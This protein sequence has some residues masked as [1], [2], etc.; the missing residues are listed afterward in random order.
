MKWF[1][2]ILRTL[3]FLTIILVLWN[4]KLI[5]YGIDQLK[6]Q[7][8]IVMRARPIKE[9]LKNPTTKGIYK[10]KLPLIAEIKKFAVDSLGLKQTDNYTTFYDQYDKP[11]LWVLTASEPFAL[12]AYQWYFPFLGNVSYKGF[13]IRQNGER[14]KKMLDKKGLDTDLSPTGG[15]STLGWFKDPV[16]SNFLKRPVGRIAETIIHELTHATVYLP[17]SVDYNENLATFVGEKG[18]ERFLIYKYGAGSKQLED[19]R[20]YKADEELYGNQFL[21]GTS[22]LD[23]LYRSFETTTLSVNEKLFLKYKTITQ[24]MLELNKQL[25]YTKKDYT[26]DFKKE[27]FPD[28][29]WFLSNSRYR[30]N[31]EEFEKEFREKNGSDLKTFVLS[32]IQKD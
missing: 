1:K 5:S 8:H 21:K 6:G 24:I 29:T 32:I 15:W 4:I 14:E 9:V 12:K 20:H 23:S 22:R 2:R 16:L 3:L 17:S 26:F 18:A 13:F 27:K 7:I 19:Y 10:N 31:Q 30:K 28:N 25:F 11:V